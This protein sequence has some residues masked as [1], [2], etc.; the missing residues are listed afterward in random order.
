MHKT[1]K[2]RAVENWEVGTFSISQ[3]LQTSTSTQYAIISVGWLV[4]S[5]TFNTK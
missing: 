1:Y 4:F 3:Q 5:G 2:Q